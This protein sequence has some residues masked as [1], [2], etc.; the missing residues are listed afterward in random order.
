MCPHFIGRLRIATPA[1]D[2]LLARRVPEIG[3]RSSF[4]IKSSILTLLHKGNQ[5]QTMLLKNPT[6]LFFEQISFS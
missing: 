4:M 1:S 5:M 2:M 6:E 3:N